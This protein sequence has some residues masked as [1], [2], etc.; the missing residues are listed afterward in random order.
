MPTENAPSAARNELEI[1][2]QNFRIVALQILFYLSV[3]RGPNDDCA[4]R[5]RFFQ[6]NPQSYPQT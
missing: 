6:V 3:H 4:R 1:S 2:T 5:A